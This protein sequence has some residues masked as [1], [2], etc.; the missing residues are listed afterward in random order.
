MWS[1]EFL[2]VVSSV[3]IVKSYRKWTWSVGLHC[4]PISGHDLHPWETEDRTDF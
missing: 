2:R 3:Y 4:S 1:L